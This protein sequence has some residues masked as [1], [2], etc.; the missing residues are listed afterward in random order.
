MCFARLKMPLGKP[1]REFLGENYR[2]K[3]AMLRRGREESLA[4]DG[5]WKTTASGCSCDNA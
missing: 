4:R 1:L 3:Y 5:R 2:L